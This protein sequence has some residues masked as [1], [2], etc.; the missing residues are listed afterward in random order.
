M[1]HFG[2]TILINRLQVD[3]ALK[4]KKLK[5]RLSTESRIIFYAYFIWAIQ[6]NWSR[7][8]IFKS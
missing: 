2:G 1:N 8:N 6:S 5:Y 4:L 3:S 7:I